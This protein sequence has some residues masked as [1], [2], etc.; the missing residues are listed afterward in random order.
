MPSTSDAIRLLVGAAGLPGCLP[1]EAE[2]IVDMVNRLPLALGICGKIVKGL[3]L[4]PKDSWQG[5]VGVIEEAMSGSGA[6]RRSIEETVILAS[7]K[8][9]ERGVQQMFYCLA[10]SAEDAIL[11]MEAIVVLFEAAQTVLHS[12]ADSQ[13]HRKAPIS[14]LSARRMVKILLDRSLINGSVDTCRLHDMVRDH[15]LSQF[16]ATQT[17]AAHKAIV[18]AIRNGRPARVQGWF[19]ADHP[20]ASYISL[21]LPYHMKLAWNEQWDDDTVCRRGTWGPLVPCLFCRNLPRL[22]P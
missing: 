18:E 17:K 8:G 11:P 12:G 21:H 16:N 22:S 1:P 7:L 9:L 13:K 19:L 4:G 3:S 5:V 14:I 2:T 10:L 6:E 15:A 20:L